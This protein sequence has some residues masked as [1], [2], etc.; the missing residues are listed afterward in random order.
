MESVRLNEVVDGSVTVS[1]AAY[2]AKQVRD[3]DF[4][5]T[6]TSMLPL[7][8]DPSQSM[9][10]VK[11][12]LRKLMDVTKFLNPGQVT[13]TAADQPL[14]ALFKQVQWQFPEEFG[15]DKAV[16]MIGA[17]HVQMAFESL[18]GN[19][20]DGS[21]WTTALTEF[22]IVGSGTADSFI[23]ASDVSKTRHIHEITACALYT[24]QKDVYL[25]YSV[26]QTDPKSFQ[27]WVAEKELASPQ[28]YYWNLILK[29][30]LILLSFVSSIRVGDFS[31]YTGMLY[32]M[33]PYFFSNN[34]THYSRWLPVHY[35]DMA[36]LPEAHPD[37]YSEFT[38]G[39]FV[40]HKSHVPYTG[41]GLD[42]ANE[43]NIDVLIKGDGGVIG[44]TE[45]PTALL[46]WMVAGP[47]VAKTLQQ[48]EE[49]TSVNAA[50]SVPNQPKH[51]GL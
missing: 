39:K 37:V 28:F 10:T 35:R 14:Y 24:L 40:V 36:R 49:M 18:I 7:L 13:V 19:L 16:I 47:A 33:C 20:L 2:N 22:R 43:Q 1:W 46:R 44:I 8:K 5:I 32:V 12:C 9:S 30:E 4:N 29:L 6:V 17:L 50:P 45:N 34:S 31:L 41:L 11:H 25:A 48:Y 3:H 27:D 21:G 23:N 38:K 26:E 42:H 51:H 15:E